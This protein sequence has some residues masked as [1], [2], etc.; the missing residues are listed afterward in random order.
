MS[1]THDASTHAHADDDAPHV[2]VVSPKLLLGVYGI[3]V[4]LTVLTVAVTKLP[5]GQFNLM[6]ALAIAVLKATLVVLYF[7]H[8][9]WDS[10]FNAVILI[11]ALVFI[12]IFMGAAMM[13]SSNYE[14][15]MEPPGTTVHP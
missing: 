2:H 3:L 13:D 12:A 9:R 7:M 14:V 8:L 15:N 1:A 11:S 4:V 6:V 10:P 5:L